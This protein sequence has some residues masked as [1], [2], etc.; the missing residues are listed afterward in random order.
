MIFS[1]EDFRVISNTNL[2]WNEFLF[3]E[4]MWLPLS[5]EW[6]YNQGTVFISIHIVKSASLHYLLSLSPRAVY[7]LLLTTTSFLETLNSS[8][9]SSRP[10]PL[11]GWGPRLMWT[12]YHLAQC[13]A[14]QEEKPTQIFPSQ[15]LLTLIL[16]QTGIVG[17]FKT[18]FFMGVKAHDSHTVNARFGQ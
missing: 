10:W 13:L 1:Q 17:G 4:L 6:I 2:L 8:L 11:R 7:H 12:W 5:A 14:Q 9:T 15:F 18:N 16:C 3:K